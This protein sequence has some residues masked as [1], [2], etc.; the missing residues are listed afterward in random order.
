M[1]VKTNL[2]LKTYLIC[3]NSTVTFPLSD[4]L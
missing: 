2:K 3:Y 4:N 1:E